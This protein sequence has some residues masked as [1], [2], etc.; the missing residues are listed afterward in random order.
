MVLD[1]TGI[2]MST[3]AD[4]QLDPA[5]AFDGTNFLVVWRDFRPGSNSDIYGARVTKAGVVLD[6]SGIAVSTAAE[7]QLEP[8]VAF[9]GTNFLVVWADYR[10]GTTAD[11]YATRVSKAGVVLE[12]AGFALSAA[13]N[14]E[15]EPAVAFDGTNYLVV[16]TDH[17][18]GEVPDIYGQRVTP[19]G[20]LLDPAFPVSAA[21]RDQSAPEVAFDGTNYLVVWQDL[22]SGTDSDIYGARVSPAGAVLDTVGFPIAT[23]ADEQTEPAVAFDG[24]KYLVVWQD[25]RSGTSSDVYGNRVNPGRFG[26]RHDGLPHLHRRRSTR[27]YRRW[28]STAPTTWWCG[29]TVAAGR[30]TDIFGAR[31]SQGGRGRSTARASPSPPPPTTSSNRRW[32]STARTTW[33]CGRTFA[34]GSDSDIYGARVSRTGAVLDGSGIAISTAANDQFEPAVAFDGT[35][36]L[37][38]WDDGRSGSSGD[39]YGARVSKAGVVLNGAGIAVSTA[40]NDQFAPAVAFDGTNF[41][42]VWADVR[43]GASSDIYGARVS[44]AGAVLNAAGIAISTAAE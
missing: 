15:R 10:S 2:A 13:A 1:G 30:A 22:R 18:G 40:A 29:R 11:I 23:A 27:P 25:L 17:R 19:A 41:L 26:R 7:D 38:V 35:N 31:V 33:W 21:N 24:T 39:I 4:D 32:R 36:Y 12:P 37:V 5:V 44:K 6:G 43:S 34:P 3:A 8:A 28:P 16:W 14:S 20:G 9:D 42:V